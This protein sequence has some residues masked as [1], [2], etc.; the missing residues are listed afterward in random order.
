ML[1]KASVEE[2]AHS[3]FLNETTTAAALQWRINRKDAAISTVI[4]SLTRMKRTATYEK[5]PV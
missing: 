5:H 3:T 2:K 4:Q 1:Q